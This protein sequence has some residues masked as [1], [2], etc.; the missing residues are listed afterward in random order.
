ML[1]NLEIVTD[2]AATGDGGNSWGGHQ[3]R[4]V[5]TRDGVFTAYTVPGDGYTSREW[6]LAWRKEDGSWSVIAQGG[7]GREPVNLL[8][9][10]DR[11]LNIIGR[12]ADNTV[13]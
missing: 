2:G 13:S 9:S 11:T 8:A 5:H 4:I 6:R 12:S 1:L 7:A 3:T 10:P